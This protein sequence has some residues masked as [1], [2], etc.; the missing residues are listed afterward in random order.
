[1]ISVEDA[2]DV[3][4][5]LTEEAISIADLRRSADDANDN[6]KNTGEKL[7][8]L[9]ELIGANGGKLEALVGLMEKL[10]DKDSEPRPTSVA[11]SWVSF[12]PKLAQTN[13]P[14]SLTVAGENFI[15]HHEGMPLL[16]RC[17]LVLTSD[18]TKHLI[19][20]AVGAASPNHLTCEFPPFAT[21][22]INLPSQLFDMRLILELEGNSVEYFLG[23]DAAVDVAPTLTYKATVPTITGFQDMMFETALYPI[24][25]TQTLVLTVNDV[26]GGYADSVVVVAKSSN[27]DIVANPIKVDK[28]S[29]TS[30]EIKYTPSKVDGSTTIMLTATDD[31]GLSTTVFFE[32]SV[33]DKLVAVLGDDGVRRYA[34]GSGAASCE[35]YRT[36]DSKRNAISE[37]GLYMIENGAGESKT[38]YCLMSVDG[39]A[40]AWTLVTKNGETTNPITDKSQSAE[41]VTLAVGP[42]TPGGGSLSFNKDYSLGGSWQSA[43][44]FKEMLALIYTYHTSDATDDMIAGATANERIHSLGYFGIEWDTRI[45]T[46]DTRKGG[47]AKDFSNVGQA[48]K[49]TLGNYGRPLGY[50][51]NTVCQNPHDHTKWYTSP[52]DNNRGTISF[53]DY[54][55][56]RPGFIGGFD[57]YQDGCGCADRFEPATLRHKRMAVFIR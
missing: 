17:K 53:F 55:P 10:V 48:F 35:I 57:D 12:S 43:I 11:R 33:T 7:A 3:T 6:E 42:S 24:F 40:G 8:Q 34:D 47:K 37:D 46:P 18:T 20:D 50:M 30:R 39:A 49:C 38:M 22:G 21:T 25:P 26:E 32:V 16:Y 2:N 13:S 9:V 15:T 45:S 29:P 41:S 28:T 4:F 5:Q 31:L 14:V 44:E 56:Q 52:T 27:S 19:S 23:A 51:K 36:G 54:N 1:M